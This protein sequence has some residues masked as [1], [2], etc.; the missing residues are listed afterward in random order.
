MLLVKRTGRRKHDRIRMLA[1]RDEEK[2]R[3]KMRELDKNGT[4]LTTE[5]QL[6]ICFYSMLSIVKK[7]IG[8]V[9]IV[10]T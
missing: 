9:T 4:R 2:K 8:F 3:K 7:I 6:D 10:K 5:T 1:R